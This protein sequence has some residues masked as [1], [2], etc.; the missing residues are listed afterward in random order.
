MKDLSSL[1]SHISVPLFH[2]NAIERSSQSASRPDTQ[3]YQRFGSSS[4]GSAHLW[5]GIIPP[6]QASGSLLWWLWQSPLWVRVKLPLYLY[7]HCSLSS[8][9]SPGLHHSHSLSCFCI[10]WTQAWEQMLWILN[11]PKISS[12]WVDLYHHNCRSPLLRLP[13][14][15]RTLVA[16]GG[17][18]TYVVLH[19]RSVELSIF[20]GNAISWPF[21]W[22]TTRLLHVCDYLALV[23]HRSKNDMMSFYI[24]NIVRFSIIV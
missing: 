4:F 17:C 21:P 19:L 5:K 23:Y 12:L 9:L 7:R 15:N 24:G 1:A 11:R 10:C 2:V 3:T 16:V 13:L 8:P 14:D 18:P 22:S 6:I 20:Q